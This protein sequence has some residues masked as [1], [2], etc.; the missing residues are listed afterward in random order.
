MRYNWE[1]NAP[2][3]NLEN[4]RKHYFL[5]DFDDIKQ[6]IEMNLNE[7]KHLLDNFGRKPI[8]DFVP[9]KIANRMKKCIEFS[10]WSDCRAPDLE[11]DDVSRDMLNKGDI[12]DY[13]EV[14]LYR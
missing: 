12:D 8:G 6:H 7:N 10:V 5:N 3:Y 2:A 13:E 14:P 9:H 1:I 4:Y 11:I